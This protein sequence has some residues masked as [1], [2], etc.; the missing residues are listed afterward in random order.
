VR[1]KLGLG[2]GWAPGQR[3]AEVLSVEDEVS[4]VV[5]DV[6]VE[7]LTSLP[8]LSIVEERPVARDGRIGC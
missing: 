3:S 7:D 2:P 8:A 4:S 6:S 5:A 1:G